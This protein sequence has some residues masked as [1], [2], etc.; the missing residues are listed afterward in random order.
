MAKMRLQTMLVTLGLLGACG[1]NAVVTEPEAPA[2]TPE[3]QGPTWPIHFLI[4]AA[5]IAVIVHFAKE[6]AGKVSS[7]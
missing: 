6:V 2:T 5:V 4:V 1:K 7:T 3:S